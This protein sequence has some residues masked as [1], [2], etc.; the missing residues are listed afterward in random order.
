MNGT[1][2]PGS[3]DQETDTERRNA[4]LFLL[5]CFLLVLGAAYWLID[6]LLSQRDLDNCTA[7]GRRNCNPIATTNSAV[8]TS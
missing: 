7:Q 5:V 4:N 1:T 6:T 2:P 3:D 8:G